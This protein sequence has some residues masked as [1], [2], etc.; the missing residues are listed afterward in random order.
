GPHACF[1][2]QRDGFWPGDTDTR[3]PSRTAFREDIH[4]RM[5]LAAQQPPIGADRRLGPRTSPRTVPPGEHGCGALPRAGESAVPS[6]SELL[7]NG[8]IA[9]VELAENRLQLGRAPL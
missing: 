3:L 6:F 4:R 8:A 7:E 9:A 2:R 5:R 1:R